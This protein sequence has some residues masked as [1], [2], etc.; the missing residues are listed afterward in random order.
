MKIKKFNYVKKNGGIPE[1]HL[2]L[3]TNDST[4]HIEGLD[5][6]KLDQ[7]ETLLVA[8]I[9]SDYEKKIQPFVKKAYRKFIKANIKDLKDATHNFNQG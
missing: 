2:L 1:N 5:F 8:K 4:E 9:Q 3:V 7:E 6:S